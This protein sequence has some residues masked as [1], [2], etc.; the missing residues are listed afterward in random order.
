MNIA[1]ISRVLWRRRAL[2]RRERWTRAE[3]L[4]HQQRELATLRAFASVQSPFYQ[5]LHRGLERA[6]LNEL[7]VITKAMLMDNFD[8]LSTDSAVRLRRLQAYLDELTTNDPSPA[9]TGCRRRREALD[10]RASSP[11]THTNGQ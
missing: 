1:M 10:A 3:L 8:A 11:P 9:G 5:H 2:R 6:P 4:K 7:P